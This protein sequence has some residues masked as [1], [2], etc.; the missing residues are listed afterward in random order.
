MPAAVAMSAATT[1]ERMPPEPCAEVDCV[2]CERVERREVLDALDERRGRVAARVGGVEAVGVGQDHEPAGADQDRD[3]RGEEVVVAEG[4][5][6]GR[7][8]VV[9]VDDRDHA[10]LEQ[11]AERLA[12]VE[13]A[14]RAR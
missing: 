1:F 10:P 14:R 13:V 5:L 6:V 9:L 3:L 8:R 12:R 4:D 2:I 11:L 7:G